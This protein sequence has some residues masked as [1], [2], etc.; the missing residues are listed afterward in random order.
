MRGDPLGASVSDGALK[1]DDPELR[2]AAFRAIGYTK[3]RRFVPHCT[4]GLKDD[5]PLVVAEAALSLGKINDPAS[6]DAIDAIRKKTLNPGLRLLLDEALAL[7]GRKDA[8]DELLAELGDPDSR[9]QETSATVLVDLGEKRAIPALRAV[10]KTAL[11]S[12]KVEPGTDVRAAY[13]LAAL[14]DREAGTILLRALEKG[15][16]E[17][18]REAAA[19][20]GVLRVK[21]AAPALRAAARLRDR[22]LRVLAIV[23]LG[24]TGDATSGNDLAA[25]LEDPDPVIRYASCVGLGLLGNRKAVPLL[26]SMVQ[27]DHDFVI[28]AA[29]EALARLE[30]RPLAP[31]DPRDPAVLTRLRS[32]ER[33]YV[34]RAQLGRLFDSFKFLNAQ[35]SARTGPA[36]VYAKVLVGYYVDT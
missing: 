19:A 5:N 22:Q 27:D 31:A 1:S 3:D 33:E 21:E 8:I 36:D 34:Y 16:L 17:L 11:E 6:A 10:L 4:K 26:K 25:A 18:K 13:G 12:G 29:N 23:A 28:A 9:L 7:I 35:I 30:E 14:Q 2:R 32:L 20:L 15:S 24:E